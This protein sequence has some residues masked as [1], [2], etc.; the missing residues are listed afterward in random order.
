MRLREAQAGDTFGF[1]RPYGSSSLGLNTLRNA[2]SELGRGGGP[3]RKSTGTHATI[4][5]RPSTLAREKYEPDEP[6]VIIF[7]WM[8]SA[9]A[10]LTPSTRLLVWHAS[11]AVVFAGER[12]LGRTR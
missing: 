11:Q 6:L 5:T 12:G 3:T 4:C 7:G 8:P 2:Q 10:C 9:M 1:S